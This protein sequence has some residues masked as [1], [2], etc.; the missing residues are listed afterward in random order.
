MRDSLE[1]P[2]TRFATAVTRRLAVE[3]ICDRVLLVV[4]Q[5]EELLTGGRQDRPAVVDQIT[6]A[7]GSHA[8]LKVILIMRDDFYPQLAVLAPALLDTAVPGLFN[9]PGTLSQQDRH[10][11]I[12]LPAHDVGLGLQLG[13]A[14]QIVTDVLA[15][16]PD[17]VR[18]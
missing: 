12:R 17:A 2:P 18:S 15:V 13:L 10:D 7:I 4:D 11:I 8:A 1:P 3:P 6:T 5:L 16:T 9:M 14:E